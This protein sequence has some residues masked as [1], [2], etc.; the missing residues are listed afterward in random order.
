MALFGFTQCSHWISAW[1]TSL[2][3]SSGQWV[4]FP[5]QKSCPAVCL[6]WWRPSAGVWVEKSASPSGE[7]AV[8]W[9]S[10]AGCHCKYGPGW[11]PGEL[12]WE[13][14][15]RLKL[16]EQLNMGI[17]LKNKTKKPHT[18]TTQDLSSSVLNTFVNKVKAVFK[19]LRGGFTECGWLML[20][21]SVRVIQLFLLARKR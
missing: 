2:K 8:T 7:D 17:T 21:M 1:L 10:P 13:V 3:D 14:S 4:T 5:L 11:I 6:Y 18:M 9:R 20:V 16:G 15:C 19:A 12:L